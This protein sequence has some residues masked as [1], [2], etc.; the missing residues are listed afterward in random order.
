MITD[1]T[2]GNLRSQILWFALPLCIS[3]LFQQLY[4]LVDTLVV[5]RYL[6]VK[7]LAAVGATS[8]LSFLVLGF[9]QGMTAGFAIITAQRFGY[10]QRSG[11]SD[12]EVRSSLFCSVVLC[13]I[14]TIILTAASVMLSGWM[15]DVMNTP[16]DIYEDSRTYIQIIFW[17]I[18]ASVYYNMIAA[19][20]RALGDSRTPLYFLIFASLLNVV[21]DVLYVGFWGYGV[22][23]AAYATVISQLVSAVL[24][25]IYSCIRFPI[26]R[27]KASELLQSLKGAWVHL[28]AG[29]PMALQCSVTAIG[30]M[31]IQ[32]SLNGFGS[33]AVAGFTAASRVGGFVEVF[34]ISIGVSMAS[35]CGQNIGAGQVDRVKEGVRTAVI[36]CLVLCAISMVLVF[37]LG[38][39]FI[40]LFVSQADSAVMGYALEYLNAMAA[41]FP[42][43][44]LLI[45]YRNCLQGIGYAF[46]PFL[47]GVLELVSRIIVCSF[48]PDAIGYTGVALATP[49]AW[50]V[51]TAVLFGTYKGWKRRTTD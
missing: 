12:A 3:N 43:L 7:A 51:T 1:M 36:Y 8:S 31:I 35:F 23:G 46:I 5:G 33:L 14:M 22:D 37:F 10:S 25:T 32:T 26:L 49:A 47:G 48:L 27:Y 19:Q 4:N 29:L 21:L 9:V 45:L 6:G 39:D 38:K 30:V 11:A 13:V 20:L 40:M 18:F 17:G 16:A 2:K 24:C 50:I 15:L 41:F 44:G 28:R 42:L 34:F